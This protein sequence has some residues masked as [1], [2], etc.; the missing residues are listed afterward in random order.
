M[1]YVD[2]S[3]LVKRYV[4]E[5]D[6]DRAIGLLDS[7]MDWV[8]SAVAEIE[9]RRVLSARLSAGPARRA[10]AAFLRDW[11]RIAVVALDPTTIGR[12]AS[13]AET[14]G[15]RNLDAIHL[16]SATRVLSRSMRVVTF[17][18]RMAAVARSM[19]LPVVG[20]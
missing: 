7:D 12:A 8:A 20:A 2:S 13:L 19:G 10:R 9:V 5:P 18:V 1:Q 15:A 17:D 16:A 4:A 3:A 11:E 14:T 6:S